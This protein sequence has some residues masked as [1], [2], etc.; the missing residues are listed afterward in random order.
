MLLGKW[1]DIKCIETLYS[2]FLS[3]QVTPRKYLTFDFEFTMAVL[4]LPAPQ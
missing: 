2:G 3:L 4:G 1:L